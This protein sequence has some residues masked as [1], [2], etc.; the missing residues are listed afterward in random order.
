[1]V[2]EIPHEK[3]QNPWIWHILE[4]KEYTVWRRRG[5]RLIHSPNSG[6]QWLVYW[7]ICSLMQ[8]LHGQWSEIVASRRMCICEIQTW[9]RLQPMGPPCRLM[10][11]V[12]QC[13]RNSLYLC[14]KGANLHE[15]RYI[16]PLSSILIL[17]TYICIGFPS[18]F[19]ERVNVAGEPFYFY[20]EDGRLKSLWELRICW[21]TMCLVLRRHSRRERG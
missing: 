13:N 21:V 16:K 14:L 19:S 6:I 18:W 20:S 2:T 17:F 5:E 4:Y 9:W 15:A 11:W 7:T 12:R 3:E 10:D 1:M 8:L